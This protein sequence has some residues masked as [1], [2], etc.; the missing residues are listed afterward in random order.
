MKTRVRNSNAQAPA[1][2]LVARD[3]AAGHI[4]WPAALLV[5]VLAVGLLACGGG[6]STANSPALKASGAATGTASPTTPAM[7]APPA[8]TPTFLPAGTAP[9]QAGAADICGEP[10]S[11]KAQPPSSIPAYPSAHLHISQDYNNNGLFGYCSSADVSSII[12]F[13]AQQLP[14]QGWLNIQTT[15]IA[16]VQQLTASRGQT[17]L[18]VTA[19]PSATVAGTTDILI[20]AMNLS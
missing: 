3:M 13:Y 15:S 7:S 11:V 6:S 16:F 14:A 8:A 19:E 1:C 12:S 4:P 2:W 5:L 17:Q 9:G 20:T 18:T 10:A